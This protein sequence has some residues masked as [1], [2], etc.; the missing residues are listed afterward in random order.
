MRVDF[1]ALSSPITKITMSSRPQQGW[2]IANKRL[3]QLE[4]QF[5]ALATL[6][7]WLSFS[8]CINANC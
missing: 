1:P 8:S 4:V 6:S 7:P 3:Q 5:V 2:K